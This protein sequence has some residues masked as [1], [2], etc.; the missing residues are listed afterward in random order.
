[1]CL[2]FTRQFSHPVGSRLDISSFL[3]TAPS[4]T[5]TSA[6][7]EA[8]FLSLLFSLAPAKLLVVDCSHGAA[9]CGLLPQRRSLWI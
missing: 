3:L 6:S 1:M 5:H 2:L 7:V 9:L 8:Y 4:Y